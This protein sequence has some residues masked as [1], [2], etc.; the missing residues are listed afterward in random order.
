MTVPSKAA[1]CSGRR[2]MRAWYQGNPKGEKTVK[3]EQRRNVQP[4]S[5]WKVRYCW[6]GTLRFAGAG[7]SD[8]GAPAGPM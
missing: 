5:R 4:R 7:T 2:E 6:L 1:G 3:T 8:A